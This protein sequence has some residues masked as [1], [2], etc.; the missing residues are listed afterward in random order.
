MINCNLQRLDGPVRGNGKIIQELEAIFRGAGWNVIKVIWGTGWDELLARDTEGHLVNKMNKTLDGDYQR[1]RAED[2]AYIREHFFGPEPELRALVE[3]WTDDQ[4]WALRRGGL[5]FRKIY[6]A[7]R[8]A[9]ELTGA[10]T[11]ILA[12]T[13]KGWTLGPDV[14]GRNAT[15]QI[16]ELTNKQLLVLRTRL[17]LEEDIPEEALQGDQDPPYFRPGADTPE[18]QYLMERRKSLHGSLP[19][20]VVR[21]RSPLT[22][23]AG[24]HLLRGARR[25]RQGRSLDHD[26]LHP[27]A[28]QSRQERS[29]RAAGDPHRPR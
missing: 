28:A 8:A 6:S 24:G 25:E 20:R 5:D 14:E 26:G 13:I 27:P 23:P 12:K 17:N 3:D 22:L 9:T 1:L 7:Y 11:V 2:G 16:K 29:V 15:H 4:I 19:S 18:Y 21:I 10:P